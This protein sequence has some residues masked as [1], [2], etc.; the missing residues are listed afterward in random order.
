MLRLDK[1]EKK[2]L[3]FAVS[4]VLLQ[5]L[6]VLIA[7]FNGPRNWAALLLRGD[8]NWYQQITNHGYSIGQ[9]LGDPSFPDPKSN[10]T[11]Y[12]LLP[13]LN[14][15]FSILPIPSDVIAILISS[16]CVLLTTI[17]LYKFLSKNYSEFIAIAVP[18]MWVF[19]PYAIVLLSALTE[20]LFSLLTICV[21]LAIQRKREFLASVFMVGVCLTRTSGAAVALAVLIYFAVQ[22]IRKVRTLKSISRAEWTLISTSI[23]G[24][25]L[26]PAYV[27]NKIGRWDAYFY[28]AGEQWRSKFDGGRSFTLKTIESINIFGTNS[29]A[30]RDQ[31]VAVAVI[32]SLSLLAML[33]RSRAE[34]LIWLTTAGI[35]GMA[36]SQAGYFYVKQRF[37]APAFFLFIPVATW[38]EPKGK[39]VKF[40][41]AISFLIVNIATTWWISIYWKSSL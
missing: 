5:H 20:P 11:F 23:I 4:G 41:T 17:L 30:F 29:V 10:Y 37:L 25:L 38:L 3:L 1:Q 35:I 24:P 40:G 13:G 2:V 28:L 22:I 14:K 33:I 16:A 32:V 34:L 19:Q 27:A 31:Y 12:P 18:T 21:L 39:V 36:A 9:L 8:G 26:W 6:V 15:V 7:G